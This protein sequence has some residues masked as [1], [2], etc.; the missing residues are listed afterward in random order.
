MCDSYIDSA[1]IW[2]VLQTLSRDPSSLTAWDKEVTFNVTCTLLDSPNLKLSPGPGPAKATPSPYDRVMEAL[3]RARAVG[4][5]VPDERTVKGAKKRTTVWASRNV[6][7]AR[8]AYRTTTHDPSFA[9]WL[10]WSITCAWEENSQRLGAVF[11]K[12]FLP[13]TAKILDCSAGDLTEVWQ[14]SRDPEAVRLYARRKPGGDEAYLLMCGAYVV[15]ALLRGRYHDYVAGAKVD[16][17]DGRQS[18]SIIHHPIRELYLPKLH[19]AREEEYPLSKTVEYLASIILMG[20]FEE[21]PDRRS[22]TWADNMYKVLT[23]IN[24]KESDLRLKSRDRNSVDCAVEIAHAANIRAHHHLIDA[25]LRL[26]WAAGVGVATT[27]VFTPWPWISV[28]ASIAA[29]QVDQKAK[30]VPWGTRLIWESPWKLRRLAR[31]F[32]SRVSWRRGRTEL[33]LQRKG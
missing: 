11:N 10:D 18:T 23:T 21:S 16:S 6:A 31:A 4:L 8:E 29:D 1:S 7:A 25:G 13:Q 28:L 22:D 9:G 14:M 12:E 30:I 20:A 5:Y 3:G 33:R 27:F 2:Q 32:P 19:G 15:S 26:G 17:P 24:D